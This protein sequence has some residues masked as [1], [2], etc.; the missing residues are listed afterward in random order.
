M[1]ATKRKS[2]TRQ[3]SGSRR[4][5]ERR[6]PISKTIAEQLLF[7]FMRDGRPFVGMRDGRGPKRPRFQYEEVP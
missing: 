7:P 6:E 1:K 2:R 3:S 4:N 5:T